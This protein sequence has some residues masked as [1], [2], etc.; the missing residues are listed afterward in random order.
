MFT[1]IFKLICQN[2]IHVRP[3]NCLRYASPSQPFSFT[4]FPG[5]IFP[6]LTPLVVQETCSTDFI[7]QKRVKKF[8]HKL[9]KF[10][11]GWEP[12]HYAI[13]LYQ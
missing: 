9:K 13:F 12:L 10:L 5:F 1:R 8:Q 2:L 6:P 3:C 4:F 11:S 7:L